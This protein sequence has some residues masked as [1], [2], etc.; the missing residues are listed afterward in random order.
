[1]IAGPF[2]GPQIVC[3]EQRVGIKR[4]PETEPLD[5]VHLPPQLTGLGQPLAE[6]YASHQGRHPKL[7]CENPILG[8]RL[9]RWHSTCD[10][11][12]GLPS[13]IFSEPQMIEVPILNDLVRP[14]NFPGEDKIFQEAL[15]E[16]LCAESTTFDGLTT[17]GGWD[18]ALALDHFSI[19]SA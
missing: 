1:M 11:R 18:C 10:A 8:S 2:C 15:A 14:N 5:V 9:R 12:E 19:G 17:L 16:L 13:S 3:F 4:R 6:A 7:T